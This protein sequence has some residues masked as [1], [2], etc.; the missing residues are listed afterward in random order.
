MAESISQRS[1]DQPTV[2]VVGAPRSDDDTFADTL[3]LGI[4]M[5][6]LGHI[7]GMVGLGLRG[8]N[9]N[10][11]ESRSALSFG[12]SELGAF[13]DGLRAKGFSVDT[14]FNPAPSIGPQPMSEQETND[15]ARADMASM[16]DAAQ[17]MGIGAPTGR[18]PGLSIEGSR[19]AGQTGGLG[20]D[21]GVGGDPG[22]QGGDPGCFTAEVPVLM[23]DG[24]TKPICEVQLGDMVAAFDGL[25]PL[26]AREVIGVQKHAKCAIGFLDGGVRV[27]AEHMFLSPS[28]FIPA[29]TIRVDQNL[30][31]ADG[32][33]TKVGMFAP[34]SGQH[35]VYNIEV[36]GLHTFVAG[37][38]RVHNS[39]A[40]GGT[41]LVT[42]QMLKGPD[43]QGPDEGEIKLTVQEGEVVMVIPRDLVA[44]YGPDKFKMLNKAMIDGLHQHMQKGAM[45]GKMPAMKRNSL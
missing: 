27:T 18:D 3:G 39:K 35:T 25:G 11:R 28:G 26:L 40:K 15:T 4:G 30:V 17:G 42:K 7:G 5:P 12:F 23:A 34:F 43:P 16:A 41:I 21:S 37:G 6:G 20:N 38:F 29:G 32:Q 8:A 22:G 31:N 19:E 24:S 1:E 10:D 9:M 2:G 44:R 33:A 13:F 14:S 36:A 45:Q